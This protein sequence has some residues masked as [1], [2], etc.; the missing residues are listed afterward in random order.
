[1]QIPVELPNGAQ[2]FLVIELKMTTEQKVHAMHILG[3][4]QE[5]I[6]NVLG[7]EFRAYAELLGAGEDQL[8]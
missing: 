4:T 6:Q 3:L 2:A 1:M 5:E 8:P 7:Q